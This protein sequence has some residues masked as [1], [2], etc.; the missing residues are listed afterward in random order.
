TGRAQNVNRDGR[1]WQLVQAAQTFP[2]LQAPNFLW[3]AVA[4]G[5]YALLV[6]PIMFL[7]FRGKKRRG[8]IWGVVPVVSI[9]TC[10]GLY[11]YGL[12][13]HGSDVKVSTTSQIDLGGTGQAVV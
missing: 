12:Y 4:F 6:G 9:I 10:F 2:S 11:F 8:Y 5:G 13:Q 7:A 3:L 1:Y